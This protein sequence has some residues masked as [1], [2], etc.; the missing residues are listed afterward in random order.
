MP[1]DGRAVSAVRRI[2]RWYLA[3]VYRRSE[4]PGV[5]PFYCDPAR[6]GHYAVNPAALGA[7]KPEALFRLLVVLSMYQS[8]RDVDIMRGQRETPAREVVGMVSPR[9]IGRRVADSRCELLKDAETFETECSVRRDFPTGRS[10]CDHRPRTP[11]HVKEATATIGRMGHLGMYPTSAWF[12]LGQGDGLRGVFEETCAVKAD[13]AARA[14]LLVERVSSVHRIGRKLATM[15]VSAVSTPE[16]APDLSPWA[17][18]VSGSSLVVVDVNVMAAADGLT[19]GLRPRTYDTFVTF[20]RRLADAVD[21]SELD[22]ALPRRSPRLLQHALYAY[23]SRSNRAA[24]GDPC[25]VSA[26]TECVFEVCPFA[27]REQQDRLTLFGR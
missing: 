14:A 12:R 27:D 19:P 6:V 18:A 23:R 21:L 26:C 24:R 20:V 16:L 13:P 4:G 9:A 2:V 1:P 7:G 10:T 22:P 17:P 8:R 15:F 25:A 5:L 3:N 11:C